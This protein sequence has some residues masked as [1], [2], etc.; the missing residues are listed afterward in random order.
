MRGTANTASG[1]R[2]QQDD[3]LDNKKKGTFDG[4]IIKRMLGYIKPFKGL[5]AAAVLL[6]AGGAILTPLRPWLTRIAI[7]DHISKGDLHGLGVISMI[8][9]A[10]IVLDGV[11]QYAATWLTQLLGQK[12]VYAIRLDIFRHLQRLPIRYFDRNPVGRIITRTTNDVEALNEMLSSGL[13]TIIGDILQLALIVVMMFLSDWRLTLVVLS[14]LPVMIY[15][16]MAFKSRVRQAFTDVRTH[17]A[18]LNSFFQEHIT[19]MKVVQLFAREEAEFSK[20]ASINADHRDANIRSVHYFSI[21]FPLIEFLSSLAAGLVVW[22]S[23][24][25][26]LKGSLSV[27]VV[28][29]FVQYIWLFFRPLQ[30]LSDRFNVMQ[31]AI[32]SSDRIIKLLEEPLELEPDEE[33]RTAID[34]FHD[35]ILFDKVWFSY[36]ENHWVLR[37][38]SLEIKAGE[39]VAIVGATGSGKTTLTNI[40]SRFYPYQKGSVTIDGIELS[41]IA[42][43]QLR[44]LVGVVMQ[45]VVLFTGTIRENLSFGDPSISDEKIREASKIVG[46]NRFIEKLPGGYDYRIREN[47]SGLSAGQKQLLAFVRALL[48]NPDI[49]VLDEATSSVDTETETLIEQATDRL[50]RHRTSIII[51]HRLSTIQH[52]DKIVVLHKGTIRETGTHQELLAQRGL[53]YKLYLLQHPERGRLEGAA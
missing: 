48:Y 25:W 52:A 46:A 5:V 3:T 23:A 8:L 7:D 18:R 51:A 36:D 2:T 15:S 29:S 16:T 27:G 20:H 30:H 45:D 26:V 47:G 22:F 38:I 44:K 24:S 37:D 17:L 39:T 49:L 53:Y 13:I 1:F 4:Y 9:L 43:H 34:G 28:V 21:Y 50:M 6:T 14:I 10:V 40:L 35:R 31:T 41:R 32:T 42:G 11:K 19:G 33:N 12:A